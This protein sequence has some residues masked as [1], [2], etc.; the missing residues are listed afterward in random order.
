[1]CCVKTTN[2]GTKLEILE[3]ISK[4]WQLLLKCAKFSLDKAGNVQYSSALQRA[5]E[6]E[7]ATTE[8]IT[9]LKDLMDSIEYV[10]RNHP[11]VTGY[12]VRE[13][14]L[15]KAEKALKAEG[16]SDLVGQMWYIRTKAGKPLIEMEV[17]RVSANVLVGYVW[18][19]LVSVSYALKD[20]EFIERIK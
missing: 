7:M 19:E 16:E 12:G 6:K 14:R 1:M 11:T 13:E 5:K 3:M 8:L 20:V 18:G 15:K 4:S 10:Q 2:L 17:I 9:A